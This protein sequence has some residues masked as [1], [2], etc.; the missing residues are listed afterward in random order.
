MHEEIV[1]PIRLCTRSLKNFLLFREKTPLFQQ[2][3][4]K[5][6]I[7]VIVQTMAAKRNASGLTPALH[8]PS[9]DNEELVG[10]LGAKKS[11]SQDKDWFSCPHSCLKTKILITKESHINLFLS[12]SPSII[13]ILTLTTR[14]WYDLLAFKNAV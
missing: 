10:F 8:R 9:L 12:I 4:E 13:C 1:P 14:S 5:V 3:K 7:F 11:L 2:W 6:T